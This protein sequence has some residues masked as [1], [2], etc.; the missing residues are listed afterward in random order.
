M[1]GTFIK[2]CVRFTF[3]NNFLSMLHK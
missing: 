1:L 2:E 3:R